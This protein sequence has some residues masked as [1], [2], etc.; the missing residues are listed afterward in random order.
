MVPDKM[1]AH[2]VV[3]CNCPAAE[4]EPVLT[5]P[6]VDI[7]PVGT[8][9]A[10]IAARIA[11]HIVDLEPTAARGAL[12]CIAPTHKPSQLERKVARPLIHN[13]NQRSV[14]QNPMWAA[15]NV[16]AAEYTC[17]AAAKMSRRH[18][19]PLVLKTPRVETA[20]PF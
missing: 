14:G 5:A 18:I 4:M 8:V 7:D 20:E 11:G 1:S 12:A 16:L 6:E 19:G 17:L 13:L 10:D 15:E 3:G 9:P 2:L